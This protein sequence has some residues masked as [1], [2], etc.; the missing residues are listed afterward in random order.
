M[1]GYPPRYFSRTAM[2]EEQILHIFISFNQSLEEINTYFLKKLLMSAFDV[3]E[4]LI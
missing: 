1:L 2:Q 4:A 3:C